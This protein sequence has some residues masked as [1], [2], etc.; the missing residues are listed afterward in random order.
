MWTGATPSWSLDHSI[1][2][3]SELVRTTEA[4]APPHTCILI[5]KPSYH[6]GSFY[7]LLGS[8]LNQLNLNLWRVVQNQHF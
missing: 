7:K 3:T 6:L 5:H 8:T 4:Q 2:I 1:S